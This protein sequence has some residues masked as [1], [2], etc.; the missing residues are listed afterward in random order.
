MKTILIIIGAILLV[1]LIVYLIFGPGRKGADDEQP[2]LPASVQRLVPP[3][4]KVI[5]DQACDFDADKQDEWLLIYHYDSV[6]VHPSGQEPDTKLVV[7]PIGGAIYDAELE[8]PAEPDSSQ[9]QVT[10]ITPYRLLPDF[11]LGKGQGYLGESAVKTLLFP[12][13]DKDGKCAPTRCAPVSAHTRR[14]TAIASGS[15]GALT[16]GT[17]GLMIPA[18]SNAINERVWPSSSTWS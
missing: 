18:F 8:S 17:P 12:P 9:Y 10:A 15:C 1:L 14:I 11:A 7:S 16:T 6:E 13:V 4:W 2:P 3:S 5:S